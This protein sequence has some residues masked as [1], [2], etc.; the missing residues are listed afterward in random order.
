MQPKLAI[1]VSPLISLAKDQV[2]ALKSKGIE[3]VLISAE[4]FRM[5]SPTFQFILTIL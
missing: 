3:A 1:V 4:V 5:N 2:N